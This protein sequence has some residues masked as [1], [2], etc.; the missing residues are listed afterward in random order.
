MQPTISV[1]EFQRF[2]CQLLDVREAQIQA[3]DARLRAEA[4]VKQ[5]EAQV[6]ELQTALTTAEA[7]TQQSRVEQLIRDN[8]LLREKLQATE[9]GFQLQSSTLREECTHLTAELD[10]LNS[11]LSRPRHDQV[12]QTMS[13]VSTNAQIQTDNPETPTSPLVPADSSAVFETIQDVEDHMESLIAF[14]KRNL[15]GKLADLERRLEVELNAFRSRILE[16]NVAEN[17]LIAELKE[18]RRCT[19]QARD[20]EQEA[21]NQLA[22]VKN[23]SEKLTRELRRQLARVIRGTGDSERA[24]LRKT[25][26]YSSSS[27]LSSATNIPGNGTTTGGSLMNGDVCG[28]TLRP[29]VDETGGGLFLSQSDIP[30]G[31][32]P[33]ADFKALV[34]RLSEVQEENCSLRRHVQRLDGELTAKTR[35]LQVEIRNRLVSSHFGD[36]SDPISSGTPNENSSIISGPHARNVN[37]LFSPISSMFSSILKN[38]PDPTTLSSANLETVNRLKRMCENLLTENMRLSAELEGS[39]KSST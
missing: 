9:S 35:A 5:L 19:Q 31:F 3:T 22:A 15:E 1:E 11:L 16:R 36:T 33:V 6:G 18:S 8:A 28:A 20:L 29:S 13:L 17:K 24:S 34:D 30:A 25:S 21:R 2:Q 14:I 38:H 37:G 32:F 4:R 12:V 23:R 10:R 27:S 39:R 7:S 26:I